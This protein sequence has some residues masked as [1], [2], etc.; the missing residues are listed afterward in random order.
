VT[1]AVSMPGR[2]T[3]I[4]RQRGL[5]LVAL[6]ALYVAAALGAVPSVRPG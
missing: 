4:G 3:S 1:V 6:Y 2:W 5:L